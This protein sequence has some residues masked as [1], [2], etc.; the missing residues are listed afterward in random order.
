MDDSAQKTFNSI[1][2]CLLFL[3]GVA[4]QAIEFE[5]MSLEQKAQLERQ[6]EEAKSAAD[7]ADS[8]AG[9]KWTCDMYGVRSRLQVQR[10][11]NLYSL[12]KGPLGYTNAGAQVVQEYSASNGVFSGL[13]ARFEDQ[14]RLTA[15]GRLI[16][17]LS[18]RGQAPGD[19]T[20]I[21]Y[22]LCR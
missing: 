17:R 5:H 15:D 2:F 22:S 18:R 16:S 14:I 10:D 7:R 3:A 9:R 4:A 19:G 8:V 6:F 13:N 11:V 20:V 21:A 12:K 1:V